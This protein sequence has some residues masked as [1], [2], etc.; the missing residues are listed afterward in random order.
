N[1]GQQPSAQQV[2]LIPQALQT[3]TGQSGAADGQT[4]QPTDGL[5]KASPTSWPPSWGSTEHVLA[6]ETPY[7][8]ADTAYGLIDGGA[9]T[10]AG[11]TTKAFSGVVKGQRVAGAT[12]D[13]GSID[14]VNGQVV[15]KN[16]HWEVAF[17]SG[18]AGQPTG[19][20][21]IGQ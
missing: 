9:F 6:N 18:G 2:A 12:S 16:L 10:V 5:D 21:S 14:L 11:M 8:E 13:I 7:G 20:F 19:S 17:P 1:C 3:E 4:L 15:L